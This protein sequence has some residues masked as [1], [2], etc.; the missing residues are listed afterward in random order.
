MPNNGQVK[1]S[2]VMQ[3][4]DDRHWCVR[5]SIAEWHCVY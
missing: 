2:E 4:H 1:H 5:T 3:E